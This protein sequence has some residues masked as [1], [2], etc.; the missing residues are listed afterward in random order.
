MSSRG[1]SGHRVAGVEARS[2][3]NLDLLI[4]AHGV[5][6]PRSCLR[7]NIGPA[8]ATPYARGLR[9]ASSGDFLRWDQ[10]EEGHPLCSWPAAS[11]VPYP[12]T[13]LLLSLL[14]P[15]AALTS[16]LLSHQLPIVSQRTQKTPMSPRRSPGRKS[17][18]TRR[19]DRSFLGV[20]C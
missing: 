8:S 9:Q 14:F 11:I 3:Q 19:A 13:T 12:V 10:S 5:G 16:I 7:P 1:G 4:K 2:A 15:P 6:R 20:Q 17:S 18:P